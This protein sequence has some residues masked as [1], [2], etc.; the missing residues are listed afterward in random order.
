[1]SVAN[2]GY[3]TIEE[4]SQPGYSTWLET[5]VGGIQPTVTGR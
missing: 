5:N 1:M 2:A 3:A 4:N